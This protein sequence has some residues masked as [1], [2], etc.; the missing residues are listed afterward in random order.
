M[1][2]KIVR[3]TESDLVRIVK[4]VIREGEAYV[5][6]D[7][8]GWVDQDDRTMDPDY[9]DNEGSMFD[10]QRKFGP[11]EYKDFMKFI[12]NCD[13]RWCLKTKMFY[14]K[15]AEKGPIRVRKM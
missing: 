15:Y 7:E 12:N 5:H 2:N 3:L 13:N 4:K 11:G 10:E 6:H 9:M 14:D 8:T 1:K